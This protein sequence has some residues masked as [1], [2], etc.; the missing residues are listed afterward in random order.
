MDILKRCIGKTV[1]VLFSQSYKAVELKLKGKTK[2][3]SEDALVFEKDDKYF[4]IPVSEILSI[5]VRK[6]D[7]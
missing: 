5:S 7:V 1:E 2:I 6:E 3:C 4:I